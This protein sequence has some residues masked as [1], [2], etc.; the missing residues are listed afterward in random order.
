MFSCELLNG[1]IRASIII[2]SILERG[3]G[4]QRSTKSIFIAYSLWVAQ[5]KVQAEIHPVS[6]MWDISPADGIAFLLEGWQAWD[7]GER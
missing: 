3:I 4:A 1:I 6:E 7:I 2:T 5:L